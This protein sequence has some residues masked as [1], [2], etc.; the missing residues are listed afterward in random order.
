[1]YPSE[2]VFTQPEAD[3]VFRIRQLIGDSKEIYIDDK[4]TTYCSTVLASGTTYQLEEPKGYPTQVFVNN[5]EFSDPFNPLVLGYKFLKFTSPVLVS[6][7]Q[8][9]VFYEHFRHSDL[10]IIET[11][12]TAATTYLN[13]QCN[14]TNVDLGI[15]LLVLATAYIFLQN[16]LS[17][18][19]ASA[20]S[21]EDADS[22]YNASTRPQ[23]LVSLLNQ[24]SKELKNAIEAK[25]RC[26][27]LSLPVY[28]VE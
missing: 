4:N 21:L 10:E 24:I 25:T 13:D 2:V 1:M 11:Y 17:T 18:Y 23:Y 22:K 9:T 16:D 19:I 27:M 7:A 12:D 26:K 15:D 8:I 3:I 28:K 6:G 20:I 5:V 14:L